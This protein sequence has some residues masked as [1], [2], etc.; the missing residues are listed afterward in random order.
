MGCRP[1]DGSCFS[2]GSAQKD[3]GS[4]DEAGYKADAT[5]VTDMTD[6]P[7]ADSDDASEGVGRVRLAPR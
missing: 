5:D 2:Q 7:D 1:S 6:A 3:S 4:E